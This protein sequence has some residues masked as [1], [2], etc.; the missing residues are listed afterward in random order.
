MKIHIE[1]DCPEITRQIVD[2]FH[3]EKQIAILGQN[4]ALTDIEV[5]YPQFNVRVNGFL[6]RPINKEQP[7]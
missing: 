5:E 3:N 6:L 4:F 7:K 2:A 1:T